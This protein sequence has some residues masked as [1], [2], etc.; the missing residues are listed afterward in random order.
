MKEL[1]VIEYG[2]QY[3]VVTREELNKIDSL[4][5]KF[6]GIKSYRTVCNLTKYEVLKP[7]IN[8][9]LKA[10]PVLEQKIKDSVIDDDV[11]V[12][13]IKSMREKLED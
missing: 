4:D 7:F 3:E 5:A 2:E 12:M 6:D 9:C 10:L 13:W 11:S 8:Q 1:I